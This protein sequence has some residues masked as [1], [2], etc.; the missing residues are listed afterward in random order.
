VVTV[1]EAQI[2]GALNV[3]A[4]MPGPASMLYTHNLV[5]ILTLMTSDGR[6]AP[7][8]DDEIVRG[9]CVTHAG[10]IT[11][12]PTRKLLEDADE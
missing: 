2:W 7:D 12:E 10:T 5:N 6:F 4:Q 11:H 3:P 8:F 9:T 1:G